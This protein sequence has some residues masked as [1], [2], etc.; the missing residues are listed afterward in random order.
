[1]T[2]VPNTFNHRTQQEAASKI[3]PLFQYSPY[4]DSPW[5]N[6]SPE[7]SLFVC[8]MHAPPCSVPRKPR[9]ELCERVRNRCLHELQKHGYPWP[10]NMAR[11]KFPNARNEA[12]CIGA[13]QRYVPPATI[14]IPTRGYRSPRPEGC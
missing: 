7:L 9:R 13:S 2:F 3:H 11:D 12:D 6:C 1:M 8:S 5:N 14:P 10:E 4:H